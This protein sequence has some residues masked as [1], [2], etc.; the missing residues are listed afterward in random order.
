MRRRLKG[1]IAIRS[2][3]LP[4]LQ[5][6]LLLLSLLLPESDRDVADENNVG[7]DDGRDGGVRGVAWQDEGE[8]LCQGTGELLD[9]GRTGLEHAPSK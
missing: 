6:L 1:T 9:E 7:D 8:L 5:S 3:A 2:L 4:C